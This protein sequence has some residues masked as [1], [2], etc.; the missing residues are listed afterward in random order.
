MTE[1]RDSVLSALIDREVVDPDAL[2]SA[3]DAPEGRAL[4]VDFVRLRTLVATEV[5]LEA[6]RPAA[7][8]AT[9]RSRKMWMLAAA[10]ALP[11]MLGLGGGYWWRV[12]AESQPPTPTRVMQF[13]PGVDWK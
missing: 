8:F 7:G 13:V 6:A 4:L 11:L 5:D 12:H 9:Q 2:Q 1:E 10:A 3:L